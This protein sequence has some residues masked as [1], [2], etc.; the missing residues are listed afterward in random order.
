MT[1]AKG[2][3]AAR[4]FPLAFFAAVVMAVWPLLRP[5]YLPIEDLPQHVAAVRVLHSFHDPH[6]GFARYFEVDLFRTQYLAYYLLCDALSYFFDVE[7]ANRLLIVASAMATPYALRSLLRALGRPEWLALFALPFTWNAHLILGFVNF[8][9]A[10][11]LA[12]FG[13][14]LAVRQRTAPTR[15]RGVVLALVAVGCFFSHVVP[16]ALLA[17]GSV[18][19]APDRK[20]LAVLQRLVPLLPAGVCAVAWLLGTPA[21]RATV[22]AARGGASGPQPQYQPASVSLHD[23]PNWLTDVLH[24]DDDLQLLASC[25][26]LLALTVL[27]GAVAS[28]HRAWL[29]RR[30]PATAAGAWPLGV[31]LWPLAPLCLLFY[32]VMP[33]GYDWIWPIS[34]R[35]PLLAVL[36]LIP[37]LPAPPRKLAWLIGC[38][39]L[40]LTFVQVRCV[41]RAFS[42]F[43]N[44]EV[45]DFDEALRVIPAQKRVMGLIHARWSR[46]VKFAPFMHYVAYYQARKGGAVMFTFADF[47]QSPFRFRQ[48]NRPPRVPPRW[49][50]LPQ[51]VQSADLS[52]YEYVLVRGGPAP[53]D[54]G[55][56][57]RI[58]RGPMWSVWKLR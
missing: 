37:V 52:W 22:H 46:N 55:V 32:F 20:P 29:A 4:L 18:L 48:D 30:Q 35:F 5:G 33:T 19:V 41:A 40:V 28:V 43:A 56:C 47:P 58:Y 44:E 38:A 45:G 3:L 36:F 24:G 42:A 25:G 34:Q 53:C 57:Q 16:F 11:P 7:L 8:L 14:G 49:E 12:L 50:W 13:L 15:V 6:Y 54:G 27:T 9:L 39:L 1:R 51:F 23:M 26:L 31:R 17:L 2:E 10:I 21:G